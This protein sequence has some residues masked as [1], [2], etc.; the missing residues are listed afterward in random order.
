M[1]PRQLPGRRACWSITT[2]A[3][4]TF[5]DAP[6]WRWQASGGPLQRVPPGHDRLP[7][8]STRRRGGL[9]QRRNN[10]ALVGI[11]ILTLLAL[12]VVWPRDPSRYFGGLPLPGSPGLR[13]SLFGQSFERE[14]F[15][16]GLDLQGGTHLVL[17]A[18]MTNV[19]ERERGD[20]LEGV[21][22]VIERRI[23]AFGV[24]E[25]IIQTA[26]Q[27]RV[28]VELAGIRDIEQAK[29]L[30][31]KTAQLDFREQVQSPDGTLEWVIAKAK[32]S[33]GVERELTGQYFKNAE[34]GFEPGTNR[35]LILFEFN[36]EGAK[37]FGE[38]TQRLVGKPLGIFLDNQELTAPIVREPITQGRGQI[39]GRFTLDE[40]K[41]LVIQLNAG[42]LPV[43]VRVIEERTVDAT[44]GSDSVRKSVVAGELGLLAVA[45]FMIALYRVPGVMA[46]L[47]LGVY[48]LVTLAI[49]KLWP[50]TLTLAGIAGFI[51]SIGMAVD[52]NILVFERMREELR[53]GRTVLAAMEAGFDRAWSSI[54]D[55]NVSTLITCAIL[56][57]FGSTFG[58]SI[59]VGF[60]VT[61]AIGVLVSM[62]SAIFVTRTFL[63]TLAA[64]GAAT[65]PELFGVPRPTPPS[66]PAAPGGPA[67]AAPG[68]GS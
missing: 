27:D 12:L 24:A 48:T 21:R 35:P 19:P 46:V 18:D 6:Y 29:N 63:R 58:A 36:D 11:L 62:F 25:P 37:M 38:I 47:A 66:A 13:I 41:N 8:G 28:I 43:P 30:I 56:Y 61:L 5:Y 44:L 59:I 15:R 49:F 31:G 33:D 4:Y 54:R 40:A 50:V 1:H 14:G 51:L 20:R 32:G 42:A 10:L 2:S 22:R 64:L 67:V 55:S 68:V 39:T 23:N 26:G 7:L 34:V 60:A 3:L 45:I 9:V 57:W 65:R 16:L 52:A 53:A 17:Q